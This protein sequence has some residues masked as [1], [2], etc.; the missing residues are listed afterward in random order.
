[1]KFI[2]DFHIHSKYSRATAKNLDLEHIYISAQ[3]KGITVIGTGDFTHPAWWQE[4]IEKLEP[5]EEGLFRLKEGIARSCDEQVPSAC[6]RPVRFMLVTEISNIYKKEDRTR[7]NHNLV[8]MPD[9]ASA[10]QFNRR[11]DAIGNINSDGRPILGLD[12]RNLLEIVLETDD[13]GYLIPAHIWTPWFSLLGSKSGFDTVRQCFEDLT[14]HI[15]AL[16][17]GLSSDPPMNWRVSRLDSYTLV[18]NSDAHSPSKLGREANCFDTELSYAAIRKAMETAD[19]KHFLGTFEFFPEEGKYHVDG[20]RKCQFRSQPEQ[21]RELDGICPVCGKSLTLGVLYRVEELADRPK[22]HRPPKAAYYRNLI[23]LDDVLSEVLQ[24]GPKTKKVS[25]A[26]NQLVRD[27]GSEFDILCQIPRAEIDKF[28]IPLL[29]EAIYRMRSNEVLFDPGYDGEFGRVRIFDPSERKVLQGQCSLFDIPDGPEPTK[30]PVFKTSS[31]YLPKP[32]VN[33]LVKKKNVQDTRVIKLNPE[34]QA[35][36]DHGS[37]ALIIAAGPGTGKTRTITC[38]MAALTTDKGVQSEHILAVT[39]TNKAATEMRTRLQAIIGAESS[40]PM[41]ATFHGLCW[42][43]LKDIYEEN[44]GTILDEDGRRAVLSDAMAQTEES[45]HLLTLS[46]ATFLDFIVQAKQQLLGPDDD[47]TSV[48]AGDHGLQAVRVYDVYQ[49]LLNFQEL[50]DFEDLIFKVVR[51]LEQDNQWRSQIHKQFSHIFVD[52]F[53]DIN[54]AQY[55][56]L[57][58]LASPRT[59]LCVIGDPDQAIYGFRGSDMRYFQQFIQDF[60]NPRMIQLS[61]NYRST[62]TILASSFQ[63]I[64]GHQM[65]LQGNDKVRTY[66]NIHSVEKISI[67]E[68]ASAKAEAVS[69]GRTIEQMVGGIGFHSLDFD[70]IYKDDESEVCSFGDFAV[71]CRTSDQVDL[72]ANIL[73]QAGIPCQQASRHSLKK[74][75]M[76]E[77]LAVLRVIADQGAYVDLNHLTALS[78]IPISK[79]T[80]AI[81]KK[82]AYAK[83]LPLAMALRTAIRLPI[84]GL[85][86]K[87]QQ[88]L[89]VLVRL[90]DKLKKETIS[91]SVGSTLAHI[92]AQTTLVSRIETDD[93]KKLIVLAEPFGHDTEAFVATIAMQRDT[94]VYQ[95]GVE[96]VAAMTLHASKGLEFPVVFI[97][98]CETDLIPYRRPGH[99]D[100]DLEEERRLFFV[101]M[102]RA[103]EQLFLTWARK[104]NLYGK[105]KEQKLSPFVADIEEGLK[106]RRT[107]VAKAQKQVQQQLTLF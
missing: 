93:L 92:C 103:R 63:V 14:P 38:R 2:A 35:A 76:V 17:T 90:L 40:M 74:A 15:F 10:E 26:Y 6:R 5:A 88:R 24:V 16:E 30:K 22:G 34:Q 97:A 45:G 37:G 62:E 18:S 73:A 81:F 87:R 78:S 75:G 67:L 64:R 19:P 41:I 50:Y 47:L 57:Q 23:P 1:M 69:I 25:Q 4:I 65:V 52:E 49:G 29:A 20:H 99:Y 8:F 82:W 9:L 27:L 13:S 21:S 56:L 83:K 43:L 33:N 106:K 100:S 11:L 48:A 60:D 71:L 28:N 80:L 44:R 66:S 36:V 96:K 107:S 105:T 61:R 91:M 89:V 98:G 3:I 59:Q 46:Q 70:N 101:A 68:T 102:T 94:D 54:N 31:E 7:K 51:L 95:P 42:H 72:I 39:F 12:A 55:R 32:K 58:A 77:L 84:P 53:Q 85:S 79:E 104:R 86:I